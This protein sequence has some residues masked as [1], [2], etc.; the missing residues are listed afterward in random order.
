[1]AQIKG[2][3]HHAWIWD[4]LCPWLTLNSE[5]SLPYSPG[6]HNTMSQNLHAKIQGRNLYH[7]HM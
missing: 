5:I 2:V 3:Y 1:M 7:D 4:L 6:I